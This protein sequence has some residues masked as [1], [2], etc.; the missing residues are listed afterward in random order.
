M[1]GLGMTLDV[2]L[3]EGTLSEG[4]HIVFLTK[5]GKAVKTRIKGLLKPNNSEEVKASGER[6]KKV[7]EIT[8]AAGV[9]IACDH[10]EGNGEV[11]VK[12]VAAHYPVPQ[13]PSCRLAQ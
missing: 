3:Y 10:A 9:K 1:R 2:I 13:F 12:R 5:D 4:E 7:K 11:S 8:A 6:Y